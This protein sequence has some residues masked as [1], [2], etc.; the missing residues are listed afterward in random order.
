LRLCNLELRA[1]KNFDD[2]G[3]S[4]NVYLGARDMD[5]ETGRGVYTVIEPCAVWRWSAS[6]L[7]G[8]VIN[9]SEL[10]IKCEDAE[11]GVIACGWRED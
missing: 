6:A 5:P 7:L 9:V 1:V 2:V 3:N 10:F 4:G 8:N 11:D